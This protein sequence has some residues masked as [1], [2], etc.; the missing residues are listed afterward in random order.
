MIDDVDWI[1]DGQ[2]CH[3]N[4]SSAIVSDQRHPDTSFNFTEKKLFLQKSVMSDSLKG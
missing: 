2:F 3:S 4:L 1:I